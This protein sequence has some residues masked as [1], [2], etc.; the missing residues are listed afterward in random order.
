MRKTDCPNSFEINNYLYT[1][2]R[3]GRGWVIYHQQNISPSGAVQN[4]G[5][6]LILVGS[7]FRIPKDEDFGKTAWTY[8]S[9]DAAW[10]KIAKLIHR[11]VLK[12]GNWKREHLNAY[13]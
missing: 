4:V 9:L 13:A 12:Y 1:K 2:T 5:F 11:G 7:R 6:E 3:E 10:M 8:K